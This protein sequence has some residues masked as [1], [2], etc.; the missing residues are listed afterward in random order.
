MKVIL[1]GGGKV[2]YFLAKTFL[3]KGYEVAI[4]NKDQDY[5]EILAKQLKATIIHGDGSDPYF[6]EDAGALR[7][8]AVVALT[9]NDPDNLFICQLAEQKFQVPKTFAVV[10]NPTNEWVFQKLG[11][12]KVVS[13]TSIIASLIEQQVTV[14]DVTNLFPI[15]EGKVTV[16]QVVLTEDSPVLG[17]DLSEVGLPYDSV[18]GSII[19]K[20]EVIIPRGNTRLLEGDKVIVI[21]LPQNQAEVFKVLLGHENEGER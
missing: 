19:R 15:E 16:T 7:S 14:D 1:I 9:P 3:S 21:A 4:I 2:V 8:D 20:N 5:C 6:L 13:T 12:T 11:V 18:L 17:K 10:N